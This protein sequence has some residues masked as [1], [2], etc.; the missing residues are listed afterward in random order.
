MTSSILTNN[1]AMVALQSLNA[2]QNALTMTETQIS[3]GL[4]VQTAKDDSAAWSISTTMKT[5]ISSLSQIGTDLGNA[6]S[7]L[8]TAVS[9]ADQ[10][11]SLLSQIRTKVETAA[12]PDDQ[13]SISDIQ[14]EVDQLLNQINSTIQSSSFNGVNLLD[15]STTSKLGNGDSGLAFLAATANNYAGTSGTQSTYINVDTE[16]SNLTTTGGTVATGV[17]AGTGSAMQNLLNLLGDSSTGNSATAGVGAVYAASN[18]T[19]ATDQYYTAAAAGTYTNDKGATVNVAVGQLYS[20]TA[21]NAQ[22]G[23]VAVKT[24]TGGL[25]GIADAVNG[26]PNTLDAFLNVI[27]Q[28]SQAVQNTAA[29]YG[30]VQQNIQSQQTF[31]SN[32]SD[33]LTTGV[34]NLVD[35]DMT[36]ASA[37]LSALQTQQ[38]LGTQALSI[39]NQ[40]P[41]ALL[42]LFG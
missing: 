12:S 15:G 39:A 37:R 38:Q 8:G 16:N 7:A 13:T 31:I 19:A 35:A 30:A 25:Q 26:N 33:S 27:D 10:I 32:L 34:G 22:A 9:G 24:T 28:A 5:N 18:G 29:Q 20:A 42:K 4:K 14:G 6:D 21:A 1:G 36:S 17:A 23:D 3:T 11:T 2:T 40:A 41:Q